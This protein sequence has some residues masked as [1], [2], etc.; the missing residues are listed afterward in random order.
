MSKKWKWVG[1]AFAIFIVFSIIA[2]AIIDLLG[3]DEEVSETPEQVVETVA[4]PTPV[5]TKDKPV[6]KPQPTTIEAVFSDAD[7]AEIS[8]EYGGYIVIVTYSE[9]IT[10]KGLRDSMYEKIRDVLGIKPELQSLNFQLKVPLKDAAGNVEEGV[11]MSYQLYEDTIE[12][13]NFDNLDGVD[14]PE[15]AN[16]LYLHPSFKD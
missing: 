15:I 14:I 6:E 3:L 13:I 7:N 2:G 10:D 8:E 1:G 4:K 9:Y 5:I 12:T 16:I 11:V